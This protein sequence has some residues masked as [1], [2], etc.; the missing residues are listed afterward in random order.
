MRWTPIAIEDFQKGPHYRQAAVFND[1]IEVVASRIQAT[2]ISY[3]TDGLGAARGFA[4]K[5]DSGD[6]AYLEQSEI[7]L[8]RISSPLP[9]T[10]PPGAGRLS[11]KPLRKPSACSTF[12]GCG[13]DKRGVACRPDVDPT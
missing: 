6:Y 11:S 4:L 9:S 7:A 2:S 10:K 5:S 13:H 3:D 12:V 8:S 1:S